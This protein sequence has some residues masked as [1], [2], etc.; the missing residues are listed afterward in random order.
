MVTG[1][2]GAAPSPAC[3]TS[4]ISASVRSLPSFAGSS[5][6]SSGARSRSAARISTR[7]IEST[8]RSASSSIDGLSMSAG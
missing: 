5:S 1:A 4:V 3:S 2:A 8:P 6:G 7:L